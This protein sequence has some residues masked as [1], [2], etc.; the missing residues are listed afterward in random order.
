MIVFIELKLIVKRINFLLN[1]WKSRNVKEEKQKRGDA[2]IKKFNSRILRFGNPV[3]GSIIGP[4]TEFTKKNE[5]RR[6]KQSW[7]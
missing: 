3:V 5:H 4:E 7:K 1:K 2:E 6:K